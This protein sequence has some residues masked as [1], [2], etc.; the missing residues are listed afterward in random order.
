M[1]VDE[2]LC[3]TD[4]IA[5][6]HLK[7]PGIVDSHGLSS[8]QNFVQFTQKM[9]RLKLAIF[10]ETYDGPFGQFTNNSTR[11]QRKTSF[12]VNVGDITNPQ[13]SHVFNDLLHSVFSVLGLNGQN[14]FYQDVFDSESEYLLFAIV[15]SKIFGM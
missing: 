6:P 13:H 7:G 12:R 10:R 1:S 11:F 3:M 15:Q 2:F 4:L 5:L 9:Y 8:A 14:I